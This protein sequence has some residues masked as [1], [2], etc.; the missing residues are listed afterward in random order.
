M[1]IVWSDDCLSC[2]A[3]LPHSM[4]K[5]MQA[6]NAAIQES[7]ERL[8]DRHD[9]FEDEPETPLAVQPSQA[10]VATLMSILQQSY[11]GC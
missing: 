7:R 11:H 8:S 5:H 4:E 3:G 9:T 2:L 6:V 10:D 1:S